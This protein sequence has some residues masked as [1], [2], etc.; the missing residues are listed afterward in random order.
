MAAEDRVPS[1]RDE[2][3]LLDRMGY[4]FL[5]IGFLSILLGLMLDYIRADLQLTPGERLPIAI[6]LQAEEPGQWALYQVSPA[7][8]ATRG[9]ALNPLSFLFWGFWLLF[10]GWLLRQRGRILRGEMEAE[11]LARGRRLFRRFWRR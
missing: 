6:E 5:F 7:Y 10:V 1:G 11:T 8:F 2:A 4:F 9:L 3:S